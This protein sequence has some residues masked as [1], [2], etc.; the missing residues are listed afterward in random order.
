MKRKRTI[1]RKMYSLII[2]LVFTVSALTMMISSMYHV[3]TLEGV[4]VNTT[5]QGASSVID[6]LS[7]DTVDEL[8]DAILSPQF[9][10]IYAH[11]GE[12]DYARKLEDFLSSR[13]VLMNF[14]VCRRRLS[15]IT[16]ILGV[17]D[18]YI[19][20]CDSEGACVVIADGTDNYDY[21]GKAIP[22][23]ETLALMKEGGDLEISR[24]A[25]GYLLTKFTEWDSQDETRTLF[26]GCD[27]DMTVLIE[28]E[29]SF[30]LKLTLSLIALC[31]LTAFIANRFIKRTFTSPILKISDSATRFRK[32]YAVNQETSV[33][34][35]QISTN[36]EIQELS[37]S[38]VDLES[39][40]LSAVGELKNAAMEK[41]RMNAQ[42]SIATDIQMGML[43]GD[44]PAFP[45]HDEF[46]L[47][48][49][50]KPARQVG[51]DFYDF[52]LIDP[53]HLA[54][55]IGDVSDKGIP[56][57]LFMMVSKTLI[58][59]YTLSGLAPHEVLA[60]VNNLLIPRNKAEMFVTVWL[61]I[62]DLKTGI[63]TAANAGHEYPCI[64]FGNEP[65]KD[66]HD[67]HGMVIGTLENLKYTDYE[68]QFHPGDCLFVYSDGATD[69]LNTEEKSFGLEGVVNSLNARPF[70]SAK[71][72]VE[73]VRNDIETH[74]TGMDQF[75]DTTL[76]A[77]R[78]NH[79]QQ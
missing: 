31:V 77:F 52:F 66:Y 29:R 49:T 51:G 74:A 46:D 9:K 70:D 71:D 25:E 69:A 44:F 33:I 72:T 59:Q 16:S 34:D 65:Y 15:R 22:G 57:A 8:A 63:M 1:S 53:S 35:P 76:L 24:D 47:Y 10:E 23:R 37:T 62:I 12:S 61:G 28:E 48:A 13:D 41:G 40:I 5:E 17:D 21:I 30:F 58:K 6:F 60:Q 75:D 43:P 55:V 4:F 19:V 20:A 67:P 26:A 36:D 39:G 2:V 45:D 38:L 64:K 14:E 32:E 27:S 78:L 7:V 3:N 79:L 73:S 54:L 50:M 42:L 68:V 18:T 56:A 11:S